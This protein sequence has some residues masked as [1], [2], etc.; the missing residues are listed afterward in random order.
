MYSSIVP[1]YSLLCYF[2]STSSILNYYLLL[3]SLAYVGVISPDKLESLFPGC[4]RRC[5][6]PQRSNRWELPTCINIQ[7]SHCISY[8]Q[9]FAKYKLLYSSFLKYIHCLLIATTGALHYHASLPWYAVERALNFYVTTTMT[10]GD[11]RSAARVSAGE[12][13]VFR[14]ILYRKGCMCLLYTMYCV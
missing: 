1:I 6:R 7:P 2:S 3:M 4:P 11:E 9:S 12:L 10:A 8:I 14:G 13:H 5:R